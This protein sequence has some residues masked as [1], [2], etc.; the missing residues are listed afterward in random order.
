[1][2]YPTGFPTDL[3][4]YIDRL[5]FELRLNAL[6]HQLYSL[7]HRHSPLN[8]RC[9]WYCTYRIN[10]TRGPIHKI[11]DCPQSYPVHPS[12]IRERFH[13]RYHFSV[14]YPEIVHNMTKRIRENRISLRCIRCHNLNEHQHRNQ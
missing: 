12:Y 1:M 9:V 3:A 11:C 6:H 2:R 10:G 13:Q 8:G 5:I 7:I 4:Q 14:S